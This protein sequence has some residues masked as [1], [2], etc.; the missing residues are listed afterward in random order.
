MKITD[1][2]TFPIC[3][4]SRNYLF[5]KFETEAGRRRADRSFTNW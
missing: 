5:V 2:K 1:G 3:H 4:G